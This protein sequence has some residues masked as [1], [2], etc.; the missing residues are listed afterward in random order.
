VGRW[1]VRDS[2]LSNPENSITQA[3]DVVDDVVV[4]SRAKPSGDFAKRPQAEG[5]GLW[6]K[7]QVARGEFVEVQRLEDPQWARL[8]DE[9]A[10]LRVEPLAPESLVGHGG[11]GVRK[12]HRIRMRRADQH[13]DPMAEVGEF[14]GEMPEVHPL[15]AAVHVAAVRDE[16]D[17]KRRSRLSA[18]EVGRSLGH[19]SVPGVTAGRRFS[20]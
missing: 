5:H 20:A 16:T 10:T 17:P 14:A 9:V 18:R 6:Q 4:G 8:R 15:A 19:V 13:V 11:H 1:Y 12:R 3:L 7:T 2:Q